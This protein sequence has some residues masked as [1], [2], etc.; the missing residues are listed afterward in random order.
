[1]AP[2]PLKNLSIKYTQLFI[3]NEFVDGTSGK[4][5]GVMNPATGDVI[6]QVRIHIPFY[7]YTST[8]ETDI[9]KISA[10]WS[11]T[12]TGLYTILK[13]SVNK[14]FDWGFSVLRPCNSKHFTCILHFPW[15]FKTRVECYDLE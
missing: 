3:N 1:M 2:P 11:I 4:K 5:M 12:Y 13:S 7:T 15:I 8:I 6:C 10:N 14:F 9:R